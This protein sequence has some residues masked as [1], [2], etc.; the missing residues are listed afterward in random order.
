MAK[1]RSVHVHFM[2]TFLAAVMHATPLL[3]CTIHVTWGRAGAFPGSTQ[4][5]TRSASLNHPKP[6]APKDGVSELQCTLNHE[7][8]TRNTLQPSGCNP[9][10]FEV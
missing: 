5:K 2:Q 4:P 1:P 10:V 7:P 3:F 8:Q 9:Q 6:E